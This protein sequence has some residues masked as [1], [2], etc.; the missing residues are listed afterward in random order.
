MAAGKVDEDMRD[1]EMPGMETLS[2][3]LMDVEI[4]LKQQI[5]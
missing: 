5:Y 4:V 2:V 3:E 1:V